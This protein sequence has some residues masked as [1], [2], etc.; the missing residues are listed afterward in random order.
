[1]K[2]TLLLISLVILL[3][4]CDKEEEEPV[5]VDPSVNLGI[6][7]IVASKKTLDIWEQSFVTVYAHG[8]NLDYKWKTNHG[9]MASRDSSTVTYWGCP[10]CVG[11]NVV[12]C[13]VT[14][15]YGTVSDTI[16]L[17]VNPE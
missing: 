8:N 14:N 10:T 6:D 1:M 5:F 11:H 7:S 17:T 15:E 12:E 4:A 9:T 13:L 16:M 3:F 2:Y